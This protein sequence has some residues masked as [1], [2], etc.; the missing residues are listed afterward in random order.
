MWF[1]DCSCIYIHVLTLTKIQLYKILQKQVCCLNT[2]WL[3]GCV[4]AQE[5][6]V[7][8]GYGRKPQYTDNPHNICE[9]NLVVW[10]F[11]DFVASR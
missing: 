2:M 5:T 3:L 6:V 8:R 1:F 11:H 7:M 10:N 9:G 4:Q